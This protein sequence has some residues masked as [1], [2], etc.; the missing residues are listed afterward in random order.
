[1]HYKTHK[2]IGLSALIVSMMLI[3]DTAWADIYRSVSS[4]GHIIFSDRPMPGSQSEVIAKRDTKVIERDKTT[5]KSKW[6]SPNI[7][8]NKVTHVRD[9]TD[10]TEFFDETVFDNWLSKSW[11]CDSHF[12]R[13]DL[14]YNTVLSFFTGKNAP[15]VIPVLEK[16]GN[17]LRLLYSMAMNFQLDIE[18]KILLRN[19]IGKPGEVLYICD[20]KDVPQRYR[21]QY[22]TY[23]LNQKFLSGHSE[24]DNL[25]ISDG[26]KFLE[27]ECRRA[28]KAKDYRLARSTCGLAAADDKNIISKYYLGMLYRYAWGGDIDLPNSFKY[29]R[30]AAHAGFSPAFAW[31]GW[32]YKFGKSVAINY[33]EALRWFVADVDAGD[34]GNAITVADF[35][36]HGKGVELDYAAAAVWLLIAANHGDSHAQNKIGCMF[37]NGIG[38]QQDYKQAYGWIMKSSQQ[39][40]PKAIYNLAVL[41]ENGKIS[42]GDRETA[43]A[44]YAKAAKYGLYKS[45]DIIDKLDRVWINDK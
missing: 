39:N 24:G 4:S 6:A 3:A 37:A 38:V 25:V 28:Y 22:V 23:W 12:E 40:N 1:M 14:K 18:K 2:N 42:H 45:S 34:P 10:L 26:A 27:Q 15:I 8:L 20:E 7:D 21:N 35:Y 36:L 17:Y 32:H 41:N 44:F 11:K 13:V 33:P 19:H 43:I 9:L 16:K 5:Q 31:L 29:T 30:E